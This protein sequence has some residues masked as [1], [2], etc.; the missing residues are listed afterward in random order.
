MLYCICHS[1]YK[2]GSLIVGHKD[3]YE[4]T[5]KSKFLKVH[6]QLATHCHDNITHKS[7]SQP[8]L[9]VISSN[10]KVKHITFEWQ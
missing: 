8:G 3:G 9:T 10:S 7:E 5:V 6:V 4:M 2:A 1:C